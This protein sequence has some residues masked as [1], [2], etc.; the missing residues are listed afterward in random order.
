MGLAISHLISGSDGGNVRNINKINIYFVAFMGYIAALRSRFARNLKN[1]FLWEPRLQ[2]FCLSRTKKSN[3]ILICEIRTSLWTRIIQEYWKLNFGHVIDFFLV[4]FGVFL[5]FLQYEKRTVQW[6]GVILVWLVSTLV[7]NKPLKFRKN[8]FNK[9][10]G[11]VV[12]GLKNTV[13]RKTRLKVQIRLPRKIFWLTLNLI[14]ATYPTLYLDAIY[15]KKKK[16]SIF[17]TSY[18]G[19]PT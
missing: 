15:A 9:F 2:A 8:S 19:W 18:T 5:R 7:L 16:N 10:R 14:S 12:T 13:L 4:N 17:W 1:S 3:G 11:I 6:I